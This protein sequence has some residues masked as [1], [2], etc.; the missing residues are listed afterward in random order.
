MDFLA[1][2]EEGYLLSKFSLLSENYFKIKKKKNLNNEV[3]PLLLSY[4]FLEIFI[5]IVTR[6]AIIL[7]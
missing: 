4:F 3:W 7:T 5:Y 1:Y 6:Q 2:P